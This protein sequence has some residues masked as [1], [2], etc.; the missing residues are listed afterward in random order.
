MKRKII[1]L[2]YCGTVVVLIALLLSYSCEEE[3]LYKKPTGVV[4]LDDFNTKDGVDLLLTATYTLIN[5]A[6]IKGGWPREAYSASITNWIWDCA[7]DDAYKGSTLSDLAEGGEIERFIAM[8]NNPHI[9]NKW[10]V[11]YDGVSRSNDCIN[12]ILNADDMTQGEKTQAMGQA[13]FLRA[14]YHFRLQRMHYQVPFISHE[15]EFPEKVAN[16]H[17]IWDEIE[18]DLTE[19]VTSLPETWPGEPGRATKYAALALKAYVHLHQNEY[20]QASPLLDQIIN[21]GQFR[22]AEHFF[23]NFDFEHENNEESIFEV[24]RAV[25]DGTGQGFNGTPD[26]WTTNPPPTAGLGVC[27]GMYQP[28]MDLVNAYKVDNEGLPLLGFNG[29]KYDETN[30]KNSMGLTPADEFIPAEDLLDPRLDWTVARRGIPFMDWGICT[31]WAREPVNGGPFELKKRM[32]PKALT[33]IASHGSFARSTALNTRYIRYAHVLLW[34]AECAVEENNLGMAR[35]LVNQV[36]E[37]ASDDILMGR[38]LSYTFPSAPGSEDAE[39]D[40]EQPAA[41]YL[42][43]EYDSFPSQ[44]YARAAVRMELRL[45]TAMEGNR[46]FD[47]RRW[48]LL[49]EV[50]PDY[51][52]KD[53][54]FRTFM[55]GAMF[56]AS[57]HDYWPLPESQLDIQE[58]VLQQDPDW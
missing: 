44:E 51:I 18:A 9:I 15:E 6:A 38:C 17:P 27:C 46:F 22:L 4:S 14:L 52:E 57:K 32:Y 40:Y 43:G 31:G 10:V 11:M 8:A 36:R 54:E 16:D 58:G 33:G 42:L 49:D 45:E 7:S 41:N 34:R 56:D 5:G 21:S 1:N 2:K 53:S 39:V 47:L 55:E 30:L 25:N 28:S 29:P 3:F 24:Q 48:G 50:I 37:R 12:A 26:I 23:H 19:A 13:K 20:S 35:D